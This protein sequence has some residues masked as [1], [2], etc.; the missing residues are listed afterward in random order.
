MLGYA[1][2]G[3]PASV[4]AW[5]EQ[6]HPDDRQSV[7]ALFSL[8]AGR[9]MPLPLVEFRIRSRDERYLW[10]QARAKV[11]ERDE[12]GLA[13]RVVGIN[14]DITARKQSEL[15]ISFLA[16]H[17]KLTGLPNRSLFLDRLSQA[18]A[19]AKR[20]NK[21]VALLFADL[22]GFKAVNDRFG[23]QAGDAVLRMAAQRMQAC[24]RAE[25]TVARFGGD[26]FAIV[27]GGIAEPAFA[28]PVAEKLVEAFAQ[29][30]RLPEGEVCRVGVSIGISTFPDN[31]N[32]LDS[33]LFAAD[34]AMYESKRRGKNRY[35]FFSAEQPDTVANEQWILFDD[36]HLVGV[37]KIDEQHRNLVRMV[38]RLN[39][40]LMHNAA[41]AD[42]ERQFDAL[43]AAT[44]EHFKTEEDFMALHGY[45]GMQ[46]HMND[47]A[48]LVD[49]VSHM[50]GQLAGRELLVLQAVKDWLMDHI[51]YAD[52]ALGTFL[53]A[54][55][56]R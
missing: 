26:E 24:I 3:F 17:D 53:V 41:T 33:L 28:G 56:T 14:L 30:M 20:A 10:M 52:K 15:Q 5:L 43:I 50:R 40:A 21:H 36:S 12:E 13:E 23:H 25:D 55:G 49:E 27:L 44:I 34:E 8:E 39:N 11:V 6:V 47:H 1:P 31:G 9:E 7:K 48:R 35:H 54:H 2:G 45:P 4:Q 38:N 22:D 37:E 16:Y 32:A 18:I 29:E 46:A 19:Q 51:H 42:V